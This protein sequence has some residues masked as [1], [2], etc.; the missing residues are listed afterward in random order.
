MSDIVIK[1]K[2]SLIQHG[3][4]NNR[5]YLM[6]LCED[7]I[8]EIIPELNN[9]ALK[10]KYTKIFAKVPK[11]TEQYFL[12]DNYVIEASIPKFYKGKEDALLIAKYFSS[13]RNI[14]LDKEKNLLILE[15]ALKKIKIQE[16]LN[17]KEGFYFKKIQPQH[18]EKLTKLYQKIFITYPF[19]IN[20]PDYILKTMQENIEYFAIWQENEIIAAASSEIDMK[21]QNVEM[22]DFAILP[23]YRG[24]DFA[25]YLLKKME[26]KMKEY[27]VKTFYTIARA[28]SYGMNIA[29]S[30]MGYI[31]S[32]TLINNTNICGSLESMNV[33]Y[34]NSSS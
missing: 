33:W 25:I 16:E 26:E 12:N 4:E 2:N 32:G 31:F 28:L 9:I 10:Y 15:T 1:I 22:T 21:E 6:K 29:F 8:T 23:E 27:N 13:E 14:S 19:P 24:N 3:K 5:I 20:N 30:K 11:C 17:L 7:D 18:A 34:K